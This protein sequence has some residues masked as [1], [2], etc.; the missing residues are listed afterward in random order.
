MTIN[1][2]LSFIPFI[3]ETTQSQARSTTNTYLRT[4]FHF[5]N[6]L[7]TKQREEEEEDKLLA[8]EINE[9]TTR[10]KQGKRTETFSKAANWKR[11]K[12]LCRLSAEFPQDVL[13]R[14]HQRLLVGIVSR[15][16]YR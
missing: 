14:Q 1:F 11:C 4:F 3:R 10:N 2:F 13:E 6:E 16:K 8:S 9:V 15:T 7:T 12:I 5:T